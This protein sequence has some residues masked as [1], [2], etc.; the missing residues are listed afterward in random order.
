MKFISVSI[1]FLF[2]TEFID[3]ENAENHCD[4]GKFE[5][6]TNSRIYQG[7]KVDQ[8]RFPWQILIMLNKDISPFRVYGGVLIS[9]RHIV[10]CAHFVENSILNN[11][12]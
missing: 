10:S 4:C 6:Q 7:I 5:Y 11:Q 9:Q 8:K 3:L 2:V 1:A 12:E